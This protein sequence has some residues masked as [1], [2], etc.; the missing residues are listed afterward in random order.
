MV[1]Q[2]PAKRFVKLAGWQGKCAIRRGEK[3][4]REKKNMK[5]TDMEVTG[6]VNVT[7]QRNRQKDIKRD[8]CLQDSV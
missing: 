5:E 8:S 7:N 3:N 1:I 6:K 4:T 2:R